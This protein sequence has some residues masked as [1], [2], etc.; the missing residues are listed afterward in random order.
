MVHLLL[1]PSHSIQPETLARGI[2]PHLPFQTRYQV[3]AGCTATDGWRSSRTDSATEPGTAWTAASGLE[4]TEQCGTECVSAAP[5]S[6]VP[7]A[8]ADA[9]V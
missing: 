3:P 5:E 2:L 9:A 4:W 8:A 7:A 6:G 1:R